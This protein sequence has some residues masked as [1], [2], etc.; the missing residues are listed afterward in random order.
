MRKVGVALWRRDGWEVLPG[1][2][3]RLSLAHSKGCEGLS[4]LR[5]RVV[6]DDLMD[7]RD[8]LLD[9]LTLEPF[10]NDS[11]HRPDLP[12]T[13]TMREV[14]RAKIGGCRD[15]ARGARGAAPRVPG[16]VVLPAAEVDRRNHQI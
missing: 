8:S 10:L 6:E 14:E 3:R 5:G 13:A 11:G 7:A 15:E 2:T 16:R 9:L 1:R 4:Q 12:S